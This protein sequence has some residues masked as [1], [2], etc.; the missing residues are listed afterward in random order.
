MFK[1]PQILKK[2][3]ADDIRREQLQDAE[4]LAAEWE[5]NAEY[6]LAMAAMYKSRSIRLKAGLQLL[7]DS[8]IQTAPTGSSLAFPTLVTAVPPAQTK[9]LDPG[10]WK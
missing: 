2:Q 3:T 10:Q 6:S 4:R 8:D 7:P 1:L 9:R 5:A